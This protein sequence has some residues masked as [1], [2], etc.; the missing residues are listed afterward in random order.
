[1]VRK[2][3]WSFLTAVCVSL[4]LLSRA[5]ATPAVVDVL[6]P[7]NT[8]LIASLAQ[9]LPPTPSHQSQQ[10][11]SLLASVEDASA[12]MDHNP[13]RPLTY[14]YINV[15]S[16]GHPYEPWQ[17]LI[18]VRADGAC[19]NFIGQDSAPRLTDFAP[20][21]VAVELARQ[22]YLFNN[23]IYPDPAFPTVIKH[24]LENPLDFEPEPF[25]DITDICALPWEKAEAVKTFGIRPDPINCVIEPPASH[26]FWD[27]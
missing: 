11:F 19:E 22:W 12:L 27:I 5:L 21:Y 16:D 9:C 24:A 20:S 14:H 7:E 15:F 10:Q 3:F 4:V 6:N 8:P 2:L 17:T 25:T 1:M 18:G 23:K 26:P 13:E